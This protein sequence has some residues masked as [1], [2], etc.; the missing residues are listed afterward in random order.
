MPS[1]ADLSPVSHELREVFSLDQFEK[2]RSER[3]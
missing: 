2:A 1:N 3:R